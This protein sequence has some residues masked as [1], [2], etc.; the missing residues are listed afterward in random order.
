[1]CCGRFS[2]IPCV[3]PHPLHQALLV[4]TSRIRRVPDVAAGAVYTMKAGLMREVRRQLS[5]H[6]IDDAAGAADLA[7]IYSLSDPRDVRTV[8]YVGQTTAPRRR[9]L[10]HLNTA[11]LWIPDALPWWIAS[12]RLRPLYLWIRELYR[13]GNRLPIML[14]SARVPEGEEPLVAE[15]A[16]ILECLSQQLPL[17]NVERERT[18]RPARRGKLPRP[19]IIAPRHQQGARA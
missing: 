16:R 19:C 15:R 9:Y 11:R 5:S 18:A 1:M 2:Q 12:P 6:I 13:D 17:L 4:S 8:R 10:Q 3:N 14:I 7:A